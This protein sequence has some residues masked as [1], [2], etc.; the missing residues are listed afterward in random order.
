MKN[1]AII[2]VLGLMI[3]LVLSGCT[4]PSGDASATEVVTDLPP[5][6]E[7]APAAGEGEAAESQPEEV[8]EAPETQPETTGLNYIVVDTDQTYCYSDAISIPCPDVGAAFFGQDAQYTGNQPNYADNGDGT[9]TDLNT[10][11]MWSKD[12]GSKQTYDQGGNNDWRLPTIKE[13][14]SLILFS[15]YDPSGCEAET[16]CPDLVPFI[17]TGFFSFQYGQPDAGERLIDAQFIS[18]TPYAGQGVEGGLVFGV[19]FADGRI[20]GYGTGP[21][22]GAAEDKSF[23]VLYVRGATG[24]GLNQFLDNG[25][26]TI[27]DQATG[28]TW[29]QT[30]SQQALGWQDALAYCENLSWAGSDDWRLPNAKELHS[31]ID[32]ARS[33]DTSNTAAINS[34]FQSTPLTNEAGQPDYGF[35]WTSTTHLNRHTAATDAVYLAFGRALGYLSGAWTD[36]HGAGA[37]RSDPK[38]GDPASFAQGRGPQGDAVRILNYARCVRGGVSDKILIGGEVDSNATTSPGADSGVP[39]PTVDP[40]QAEPPPEAL[41]ACAGKTTNTA[42]QYDGLLGPMNGVCNELFGQ[43]VCMPGVVLPTL[44]SP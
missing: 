41:E 24:Y 34:L 4:F 32:T 38:A 27:S 36:V 18:N 10:G 2:L 39:I 26:G 5:V 7:S 14:Y 28:L 6:E 44:P 11:L 25:D 12:A 23:F 9:I 13:L 40:G 1:I 15:G 35:Y 33:P 19:N 29:M 17:D 21:M 37:Q 22:P 30:D 43:L 42:C 16:D 3:G 20:K 31:I 8:A